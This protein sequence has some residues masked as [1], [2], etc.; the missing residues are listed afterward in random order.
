HVLKSRG[1]FPAEPVYVREIRQYEKNT[2][3]F[4]R[5]L[6]LSRLLRDVAPER[7]TAL[8]FRR[9]VLLALQ[10]F[11]ESYLVCQFKDKRKCSYHGRRLRLTARDVILARRIRGEE[12][13]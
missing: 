3:R 4:I 1:V 5:K 12:R 9:E 6:P 11:S 8:W 2:E 13:A 7:I 10:A